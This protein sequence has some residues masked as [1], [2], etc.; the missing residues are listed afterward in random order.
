MASLSAFQS[1]CFTF[2]KLSDYFLSF[3]YREMATLGNHYTFLLIIVDVLSFGR[4]CLEYWPCRMHGFVCTLVAERLVAFGGRSFW[5]Q[6]LDSSTNASWYVSTFSSSCASG[7]SACSST[8]F[9]PSYTWSSL[10]Q[11]FLSA[12]VYSVFS[13]IFKPSPFSIFQLQLQ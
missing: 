1:S 10:K 13:S 3:V 9:S 6:P 11:A 4:C 7:R 5:S 12:C 2:C 8:S